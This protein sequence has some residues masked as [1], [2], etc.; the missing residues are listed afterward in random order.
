MEQLQPE[1]MLV[2][3]AERVV[4]E[5]SENFQPEMTHTISCI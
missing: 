3:T 1:T 4:G 2:A 5:L